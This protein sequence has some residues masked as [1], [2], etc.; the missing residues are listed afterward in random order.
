MQPW[1]IESEI[2]DFVINNF[3]FGKSDDLI[4][5]ESLLENGIIDST[6]VLELIG[7]LQERFDIQIEDD[8]I[9]PANLDS[10]QNLVRYISE[11]TA[12]HLREPIGVREM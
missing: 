5:S 1:D 2:R 8:E 7:F 4:D 9:I 11:K 3:Q 6:G 10:I 12:V